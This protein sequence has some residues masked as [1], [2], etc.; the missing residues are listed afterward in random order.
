MLTRAQKETQVAEFREKLGR[1]TA[2]FLADFRGL[3]VQAANRLRRLLRA[4][5]EGA[6]EYR[7]IKNSVLRRA[8]SDHQD[9]APLAK[10][11][12]GPTGLA[13]CYGDAARL[14]KLLVQYGKE[15]EVF[16]LK[17]GVVE[18]R[19][20]ETGEIATLATLPNLEALRARLVGMI[21]APATKLARV[22]AAP[23]GQLAR[24]VEARR[25]KLEE[26]GSAS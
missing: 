26:E 21:Q 19:P 20:L 2:V 15:H 8:A 14:A 23:G 24:V 9:F 22:L 17:A 3:D 10:H 12:E 11:F 1:A 6:F 25:R 7:V 18:G 4:E 5:G 16:A 13:V